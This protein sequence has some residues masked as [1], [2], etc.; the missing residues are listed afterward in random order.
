MKN[1]ESLGDDFLWRFES[2]WQ[3]T[4]EREGRR[5]L[6][7]LLMES[8]GKPG[9]MSGSRGELLRAGH[10]TI[11]CVFM[12]SLYSGYLTSAFGTSSGG[13]NDENGKN[14]MQGDSGDGSDFRRAY[15]LLYRAETLMR[16]AGELESN[17]Q[18]YE[19][20]KDDN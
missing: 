17:Q 14:E 12:L 19:V 1:A 6:W 8:L 2:A 16:E 13:S 7:Q 20:Y 5:Q 18:R 15:T 3:S 9:D 11:R 10:D 4:H